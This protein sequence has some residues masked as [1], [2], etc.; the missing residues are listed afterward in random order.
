MSF[1]LIDSK[2]NYYSLSLLTANDIML[3]IP[4]QILAYRK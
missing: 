1:V 4:K 3:P 2:K